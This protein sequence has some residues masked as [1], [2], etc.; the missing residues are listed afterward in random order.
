MR[1]RR[2]NKLLKIVI[3]IVVAF[4]AVLILMSIQSCQVLKGKY[5]RK[6]DSTVVNKTDSGQVKVNTTDKR[7]SLAWWRERW[8]FGRDTTIIVQGGTNIY[9]TSYVR[10]GG[11]QVNQEKSINYDS[12]WFHRADSINRSIVESSKN[13][14]TSPTKMI[15]TG[16]TILFVFAGLLLF[17]V[18]I[19]FGIKIYSFYK[20]IK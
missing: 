3:V 5:E 19:L 13:K 16:I 15:Q 7:D 17:G 6:S 2:V 9:P 18:V 20:T 8:E 12:L 1:K 4:F 10:E 14:E 11:T